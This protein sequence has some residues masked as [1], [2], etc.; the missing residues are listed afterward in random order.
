MSGT[1]TL[2][3]GDISYYSGKARAYLRAKGI[4][5][6]ELPATREVYKQIILPR[7]GWPVIPVVVTP[8]DDT[9]QDTTDIIDALEAVFPAAS[10]YP[11]GPRQR[12]VALLLEVYGDEWLKL[13]AMHYRWNHNTDW[14]IEQ[15]GRLS[16]PDASAEEAREIGERTCRPFRGSLPPLGVTDA[17]IPAIEASYE[18]LLAELDAH[19]AEHA[20]L[21]GDRPCIGDFGLVGPL[22][23]HQ[24]RDPASGDL[25]RRLAPN[26]VLW[27]E[28]MMEGTGLEERRR[29][30]EAPFDGE[31]RRAGAEDAPD[32]LP[33]DVVPG[34]LLPVLRRMVDEYFPVL[35]SAMTAFDRWVDAHPDEEIP[36]AVG[37][38]PFTLGRGTAAEV[39]AERACFTFDLWMFQRPREFLAGLEGD[40]RAACEALMAELGGLDVLA[41]GTRHRLGRENYRLVLAT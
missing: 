35:D 28:R 11:S 15:F 10:I 12:L 27:V 41:R 24:F 36:R 22:Y 5:Y 19:F 38:H 20:F 17:T 37:M 14:I 33:D 40:A 21:L 9:L 1:Y 23:A 25:M 26:L 3:G 7:V 8:E 18:A 4:P 34:T 13:P 32:F 6:Q 30:R 39:T 2:Y 16:K 29:A 31:D